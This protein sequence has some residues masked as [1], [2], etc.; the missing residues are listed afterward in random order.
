M[1]AERFMTEMSNS[2]NQLSSNHEQLEGP[3]RVIV[4]LFLG[5]RHLNGEPSPRAE[6]MTASSKEV[7]LSG[8]EVPVSGVLH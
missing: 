6:S 4:T 7:P 5:D 8:K 1:G 2:L 3:S